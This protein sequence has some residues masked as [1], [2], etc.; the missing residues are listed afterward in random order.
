VTWNAAFYDAAFC[1]GRSRNGVLSMHPPL[2]T[3]PSLAGRWLAACGAWFAAAGV[4]LAAY[5]AHAAAGPDQARLQTAAVF[6]FGHGVALALA[7]RNGGGRFAFAALC[8]LWLGVL[9]FCGSLAGGVIAHWPTT[10]APAGGMLMIG[11]WLAYSL[12]LLRR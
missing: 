3:E 7:G 1:V 4:A 5:A 12:H 2:R 8:M 10:L 6:A 9:L 11:G